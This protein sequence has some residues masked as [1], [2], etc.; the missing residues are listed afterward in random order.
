MAERIGSTLDKAAN[1]A[2]ELGLLGFIRI[3]GGVTTVYNSLPSSETVSKTVQSLGNKIRQAQSSPTSVTRTDGDWEVIDEFNA[4]DVSSD[5]FDANG[6]ELLEAG[7]F[8]PSKQQV[9]QEPIYDLEMGISSD[10]IQWGNTSIT[11]DRSGD[12]FDSHGRKLVKN[13]WENGAI[14]LHK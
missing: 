5:N 2:V 3:V 8:Y 7:L 14:L 9:Q 13:A 10:E 1:K 4:P 6:I 11:I 12:I